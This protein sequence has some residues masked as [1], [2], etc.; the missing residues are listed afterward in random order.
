VVLEQ[1]GRTSAWKVVTNT[2]ESGSNS[3]SGSDIGSSAMMKDE[4]R[5][6]NAQCAREWDALGPFFGP[7]PMP[8]LR[9]SA[10]AAGA[11]DDAD[12]EWDA[13]LEESAALAS[14]QRFSSY[15]TTTFLTAPV[16]LTH[17][18]DGCTV[19][20][21]DDGS[22]ASSSSSSYS[23]RIVVL[24][25]GSCSFMDKLVRMQE[26]G[27]AGV[28]VINDVEASP[29]SPPS[30]GNGGTG[31]FVNPLPLLMMGTDSSGRSVH[32]PSVMVPHR[33]GEELL[34][35]MAWHE[36]LQER[37]R[38]RAAKRMHTGVDNQ[39]TR[40]E[41]RVEL[42][43]YFLPVSSVPASSVDSLATVTSIEGGLMDSTPLSPSTSS[44]AA[45]H[46]RVV[47]TLDHFVVT[48][49][50]GFTVEVTESKEG[51]FMLKVY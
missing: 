39:W 9:R 23:G 15:N 46:P 17:P 25:R 20:S 43:K 37:E 29:S 21:S 42:L 51:K 22:D 27:A 32:I 7:A 48:S 2:Y 45:L 14:L 19:A 31:S 3:N 26:A 38:E 49:M 30:S 33:Y 41:F 16:A 28:I 44:S 6:Y 50:G 18:R 47:G 36:R 40:Q 12:G 11:E 24:R 1:S 35:C 4:R 5:R 13:E 8:L 10:N 34:G